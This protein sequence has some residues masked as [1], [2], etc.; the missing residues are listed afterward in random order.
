MAR[1]KK[2]VVDYFPHYVTH[3]K[4]MFT[5]EG[6]F[7][8]DGYAFWFKLLEM[9]GATEN[10]FIDCNDFTTWEFLLAKTRLNGETADNILAMLANCGSIDAE[11]WQNRIIWSEHFVEN[12]STVYLRRRVSVYTKEDVLGLCIQ[13]PHSTTQC[14]VKNPQSKVKESKVKEPPIAPLE[15]DDKNPPKKRS[16]AFEKF[17]DA[18]PI[19][20]GKGQALITWDKLKKLGRLPDVDVM[21]AAI[22]AQKKERA[23]MSNEGRFCPEW[24]HPSTWLNAMGWEDDTSGVDR[25]EKYREAVRVLR[26]DGSECFYRHCESNGLDAGEVNAWISRS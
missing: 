4:T 18:Y 26:S 23:M 10:H 5:I 21:T 16:A 17:W 11:L 22:E 19:K 9:L 1:P 20:K 13:K 24:K 14:V 12:L 25:D 3:G 7:G 2:A 8:N 15:S 6:K